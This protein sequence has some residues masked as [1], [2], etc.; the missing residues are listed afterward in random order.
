M[1]FKRFIYLFSMVRNIQED[2]GD[3]TGYK[4]FE[5]EFKICFFVF[6]KGFSLR[7]IRRTLQSY[8]SPDTGYSRQSLE[9]QARIRSPTRSLLKIQ[10]SDG[11]RSAF[12]VRRMMT[13]LPFLCLYCLETACTGGGRDPNG[14]GGSGYGAY[15]IR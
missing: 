3:S 2:T 5:R 4:C 15:Y 14:S 7:L 8:A 11:E 12:P 1:L 6:L 10:F 9:S 13:F